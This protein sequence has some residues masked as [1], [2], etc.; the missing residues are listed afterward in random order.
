M[1]RRIQVFWVGPHKTSI[2]RPGLTSGHL[3]AQGRETKQ[4]QAG[5]EPRLR[6]VPSRLRTDLFF[7]HD[8]VEWMQPVLICLRLGA[9]LS[10]LR[11]IG[12]CTCG[13]C[14]CLVCEFVGGAASERGQ[15]NVLR[16][17]GQ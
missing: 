5:T 16:G 3:T 15:R 6:W 8:L 4:T 1:I 17:R 12:A 13:V 2:A 7:V 11:K 14:L 10:L 9:L